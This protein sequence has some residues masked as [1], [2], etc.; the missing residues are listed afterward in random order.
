MLVE[1]LTRGAERPQTPRPPCWSSMPMPTLISSQTARLVWWCLCNSFF[2][3]CELGP[4]RRAV[5]FEI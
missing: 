2:F 5:R 3:A 1:V 4:G